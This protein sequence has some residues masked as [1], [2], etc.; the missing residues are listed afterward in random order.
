MAIVTLDDG[1]ARV[2]IVIYNELLSE[3]SG[4]LKEDQLLVAKAVIGNSMNDP[5][6][7]RITAEKLYDLTS[8]RSQ[9]ANKIRFT[10]NQSMID[11]K[12]VVP[13]LKELIITN[14]SVAKG[15][16]VEAQLV[17]CPVTVLYQNQQAKCEIELGDTW[18]V[19]LSDFLLNQFLS[20]L[21]LRM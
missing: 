4:W 13:K 19:L 2:D 17:R 9:Y 10:I 14:L 3:H 15:N 6:E 1:R 20:Y 5:N 18:H 16:L 8:A 7:L 11:C 12:L 21:N